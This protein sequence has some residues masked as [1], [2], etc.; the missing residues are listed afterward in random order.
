MVPFRLFFTFSSPSI[1]SF[2][3]L[4]LLIFLTFIQITTVIWS[5]QPCKRRFTA[6]IRTLHPC[7]R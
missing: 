3:D 7:K 2:Q 5:S 6:A 1:E 4:D